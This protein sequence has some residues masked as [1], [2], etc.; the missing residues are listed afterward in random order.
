[1]RDDQAVQG[2]S[3][4]WN[5][6]LAVEVTAAV[7]R[8]QADCVR[9]LL[10]THPGLALARVVKDGEFAGPASLCTSSPTGLATAATH[11]GS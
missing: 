1:M 8:G 6:P 4:R 11:K 5:E 2:L 3:L 7:Q 9:H 10:D